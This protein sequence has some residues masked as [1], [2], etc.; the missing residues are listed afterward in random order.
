MS[1]PQPEE[2][3]Y[4]NEQDVSEANKHRT[5]VL[6]GKFFYSSNK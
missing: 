3:F 1:T 5:T 6:S 4:H 2:P